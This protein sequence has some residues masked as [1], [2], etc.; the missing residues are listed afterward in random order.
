MTPTSVTLRPAMIEDAASIAAIFG[1]TDCHRRTDRPG[2]GATGLQRA[3]AA[4]EA[5]AGGLLPSRSMR[6]EDGPV[7]RS[8]HQAPEDPRGHIHCFAV[9]RRELL[10]TDDFELLVGY[11]VL[12]GGESTFRHVLTNPLV[13]DTDL[14]GSLDSVERSRFQP[15]DATDPDTDDDGRSDGLEANASTALEAGELDSSAFEELE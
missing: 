7:F 13:R 6:E 8:R 10:L 12:L 15:T 1:I 11:R 5:S 4:A 3:A 9:R 2:V 14:D